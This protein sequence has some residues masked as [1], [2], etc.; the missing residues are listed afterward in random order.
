MS[1]RKANAE[2]NASM[3]FNRR[4]EDSNILDIRAFL[5]RDVV[6]ANSMKIFS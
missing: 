1:Y 5:H 4:S 2:L 3:I 6:W